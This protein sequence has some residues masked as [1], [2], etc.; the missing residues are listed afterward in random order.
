MAE[1]SLTGCRL[2][3]IGGS[4][5]SLEVLLQ[6]LPSLRRQEHLAIIIVL[7]RKNDHD[8]L[9]SGLL[10]SRTSWAVKD[11]EDKDIIAPGHIY[12]APADY[13]LLVETNGTLSLDFSEKVNFS[14]PS[15]DVTFESAAYAYHRL[16]TAL[17]L[18]GANADGVEGLRAVKA[19]EGTTAVQHPES[20]AVPY[21]PAQAMEQA[22][23]DF[24]LQV[25][26][27]ANFIAGLDKH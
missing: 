23:I 25:P 5:G 22:D 21:M 20:A 24:V 1:N 4:A 15:I 14:R 19:M 2:L 13:H 26:E 6:V 17:L 16:L 8:S 27:M 10:S 7:H 11:A 9:L 12:V 3:V 18:S